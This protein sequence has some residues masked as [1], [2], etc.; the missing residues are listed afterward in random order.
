MKLKSN[1]IRTESNYHLIPIPGDFALSIKEKIGRR[2]LCVINGEKHLHCAIG[3]SNEFGYFIMV[4]K[5]TKKKLGLEV[6]EELLLEFEKDESEFKMDVCDELLEVLSTDEEGQAYF[7]AL[8]DGRKRSIIH[9][10]N[11][12]KQSNTRINRALKIVENLKMGYTDLKE[13]MR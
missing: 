12:A 7:N 5:A 1:L 11:K 10:I 9:Y 3:R 2:V 6:G 4:G 8:T 13:L